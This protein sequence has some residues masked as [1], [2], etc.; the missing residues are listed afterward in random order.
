TELLRA[1]LRSGA[2]RVL[3]S[4]RDADAAAAATRA[5]EGEAAELSLGGG[6]NGAYNERTAVTARVEQLFDGEVVY[7]HPVNRGYRAA[8]G[9]VRSTRSRTSS[10]AEPHCGCG[11]V[12][13]Y[14]LTVT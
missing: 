7:T 4:I 9:P 6:D 3:L 14:G 10:P 13:R 8:A 12:R 11:V 2:R 1:A 5:G